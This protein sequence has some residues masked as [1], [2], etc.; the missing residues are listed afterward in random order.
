[1][2]NECHFRDQTCWRQGQRPQANILAWWWSASE[3][4]PRR[5]SGSDQWHALL[6]IRRYGSRR[7]ILGI[8]MGMSLS[9]PQNQRKSTVVG[10]GKPV[11]RQ[12]RRVFVDHFGWNVRSGLLRIFSTSINKAVDGTITYGCWFIA[13]LKIEPGNY[14][15]HMILNVCCIH[16][17]SSITSLGIR[18]RIGFQNQNP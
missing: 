18:F 14:P 15:D 3:H 13:S 11:L 8:N 6:G 1:M 7:H 17:E 2:E 10:W 5:P 4:Y 9:I 16:F 12:D